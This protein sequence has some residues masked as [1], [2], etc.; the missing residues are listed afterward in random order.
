MKRWTNMLAIALVITLG[1]IIGY[2]NA[3]NQ[4]LQA[5]E[6]TRIRW[7]DVP[8]TDV[9]ESNLIKIDLRK[10][11]IDIKSVDPTS[12]TVYTEVKE[13]PVYRTKTV[14]DTVYQMDLVQST[15]LFATLAPL[16]LP[17]ITVDRN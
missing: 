3:P 13:V 9:S 12:V 8:K 11:N 16:K 7:V 14:K 1:G 5:N 4:N 17:K 6:I 15:K 10:E 2:S